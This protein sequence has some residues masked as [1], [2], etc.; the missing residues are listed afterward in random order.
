MSSDYSVALVVIVVI[1]CFVVFVFNTY[2]LINYQHPDDYNQAYIPK[3]IVI[4]GLSIAQI[5]IL[6]LPADVANRNAC[7]NSVYLDACNYTL[8]MKQLWYAVYII[9]AVFLFFI[10]PFAF[11]YYEADEETPT[12][13]RLLNSFL[14]VLVLA[15]VLGLVIGICY[16]LVGYSDFTVRR[17]ES[18]SIPFTT[19]FSTL[20]LTA[21]C[22]PT[23]VLVSS[24]S[25][26]LCASY[27]SG[28]G[29]STNWTM[30]ISFPEYVIAV[31]TIVGSVLFVIFGGVGVAC[32]PMG[33]INSF[34]HRP[35]TT[36]TLAQYTKEATQLAKRGKEIKEIVLGLQREERAG[37][38]GS[39]WKKNFLKIQQELVF[40]EQ[41][42]QALTEVFPQGEKADASWALTVLSYLACLFFG[43][44]GM[45]VSVMWLVHIIIFMLCDPPEDPF[46]NQIFIELDNA[47][48]LLGT[49]A[50]GFFCLYLLLAVISGEMQ[51]GMNFLFFRV[52]PMKWGATMMNSFLFNVGLIIASSIS[53]IQF[54]AKAFSLYADATAVQEIF[55]GTIES[56]RGIKYLFRYNIF[57]IGFVCFAFMTILYYIFFG[58]RRV[59]DKKKAL[60]FATLK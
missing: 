39:K 32:L 15:V 29:T 13:K 37:S 36:I 10:C 38:K 48:G 41:D 17:L 60:K 18:V 27:L 28:G 12:R 53:L 20:T 35:K 26:Q 46:L 2:L 56:L 9:D 25:Q 3:G 34:I 11:F 6:M 57:Q 42:E 58:W 22:L 24:T 5:S 19:D 4:F 43:L 59:V 51:I 45:V 31:T 49:V 40:L 33:L 16:A 1:M 54:C 50:F 44:V 52:H 14:W 47:W 23:T 30:R 55:G 7:K 8:P 21:P